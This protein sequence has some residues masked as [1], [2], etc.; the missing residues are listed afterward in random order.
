M[1]SILTALERLDS[2][3]N[4]LDRS[5]I[6]VARHMNTAL[7]DIADEKEKRVENVID[8]NFVSKRL[9]HAIATV[10]GL[11]ADEVSNA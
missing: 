7:L 2:A 3:V 1:S 6:G 4:K 5:S 10:E 8:I 11:L 9:D